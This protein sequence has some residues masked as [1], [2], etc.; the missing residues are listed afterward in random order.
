MKVALRKGGAD[1][2]NVYSVGNITDGEDHLLGYATFPADYK[3][4]P[5]NDGVVITFVSVPGGSQG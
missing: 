2:L 1:A 5:L 4:N 3:S